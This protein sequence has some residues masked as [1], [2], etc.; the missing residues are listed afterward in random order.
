MTNLGSSFEE[1]LKSTFYMDYENPLIQDKAKELIEGIPEDNDIAKAIKL[2]YFVRDEIKYSVKNARESYNKENWKSSATLKRGFAFCIPK[3]I[4]LA[5]LARA[6]GLPSRL[7]FV[8]IVNHMT[9]ERLKK[10]MGSN[11]FIFHGFV[12]LFLDGRW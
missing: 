11:L 6:V 9:S 3:A 1:T 8:D 12:E 4:L 7:H 2:F 10:D 5:S